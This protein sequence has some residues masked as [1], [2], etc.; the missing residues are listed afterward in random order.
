MWPRIVAGRVVVVEIFL[1]LLFCSIGHV[2]DGN[3]FPLFLT[4]YFSSSLRVPLTLRIHLHI[5]KSL[6]VLGSNT[7]AFY[8]M[9]DVC[10][11]VKH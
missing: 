1:S 7:S 3:D 11:P 2:L 9:C 5:A 10:L 6:R 8:L 4:Q